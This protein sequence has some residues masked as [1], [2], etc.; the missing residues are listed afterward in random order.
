MTTPNSSELLVQEAHK[1]EQLSLL[2][3]AMQCK[4]L[5]EYIAKLQALIHRQ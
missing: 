1:S 3:L 5:E 4:D 2:V